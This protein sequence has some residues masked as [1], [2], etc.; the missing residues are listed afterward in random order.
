MTLNPV[1]NWGTFPHLLAGKIA[2][3]E[4]WWANCS[5]ESFSLRAK[6]EHAR[7]MRSKFALH[8]ETPRIVDL[9]YPR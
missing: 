3:T 4:S 2:A 8:T 1:A 6:T 5:R 9:E 7:M